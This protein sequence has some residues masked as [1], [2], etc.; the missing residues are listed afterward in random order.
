MDFHHPYFRLNKFLLSALG[1]WPYQSNFE[2]ILH[3]CIFFI[4]WGSNI[5][6]IYRRFYVVWGNV[7]EMIESFVIITSMLLS[8]IKLSSGFHKNKNMK[9]LLEKI[10]NDWQIW[11]NEPEVR[12]LQKYAEEGRQLTLMYTVA[13][14]CS[15]VSYLS[16]TLSPQ[17]LDSI[18]PLSNG[19]RPKKYVMPEDFGIDKEK[20]FYYIY[21]Y[22]AA[23]LYFNFT[24]T[25]SV[26]SMYAVYVQ[27]VCGIFSAIGHRLENI[28]KD[29]KLD[30][31][32]QMEKNATEE[33]FFCITQH[34]NVFKYAEDIENTYTVY[35]FF[36]T[37]VNMFVLSITGLQVVLKLG[38][39]DDVVKY[40]NYTILLV[41]HLLFNSVPAQRLVDHSLMISESA[42]K[43]GWYQMSASNRKAVLY[44]IMR[45][46]KP[47]KI[48]AGKFYVMSMECFS[49]R[50]C[51]GMD[52]HHPYFKLNKFL[53]SALGL[54]PYQSNFEK[55]LHRCIFFILW[56]SNIPLMIRR[57]YAVWGNIDEMIDS[58]V[59]ITSLVLSLIK[60]TNSIQN[61]KKMKNLLEQIK[62]DWHVWYNEPEVRILQKYA[63]EGRQLTLLYTVA[64]YCSVV[65]YLSFTLSP[66]MLD[67][68][69]PLSN[70]TRSKKYALP[71]DFGI[72]HEKYFY[73]IFVYNTVG[74]YLNFTISVS[75]DSMYFVYVQH[76]CGIFS[77]IGHRLE[78]IT[79]DYKLESK[80]Q[81]K[82]NVS[83]EIFFC[84]KQHN[85]ALKYAEDIENTYAVYF[86]FLTG[87]NML[88]LSFTGVQV[89]IK[90]GN[91]D[92][93]VKFT[94]YTIL[95]VVHL[96]FNSVPAQRL[97]DHSLMISDSAYN[98]SWYQ[99][100]TSNRKI[101]LFILMRSSKPCIITAGKFYVM[102][103][104]SFS[105]VI[106]TASSYFTVLISMR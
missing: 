18:S 56:G 77:A 57:L 13:T 85:T 89:V 32:E 34:N 46:S 81:L 63:E 47:C 78:N 17:M 40:T 58:F 42:Y 72:D 45:S 35:F 64:T 24:I 5:P 79:K 99:M 68:I 94:N 59:I 22:N 6:L 21:V 70:E 84:I 26:D 51:R 60:L 3:R 16:F 1:L 43:S 30:D 28:I 74:I 91:F 102:S 83:E 67:S 62:N 9:N 75:I 33:L 23:C 14:Y 86:F 54:W 36:L 4:I 48:T 19:T 55:I 101:L 41:V 50:N 65:S 29:Y 90:L 52:F 31:K 80:K 11:S 38:S 100:S 87:I 25:V 69:S 71:E 73:S 20:Y 10:K 76:V 49:K 39:I 15:V 103:L 8:I 97:V 61:N 66:Q 96:L 92:D 2:K 105:K 37:G 88:I 98:S 93:V 7:D 104:K 12:I 106:R 95:L 82:K 44:I 27:H 53:L